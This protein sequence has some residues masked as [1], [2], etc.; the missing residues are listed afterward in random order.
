MIVGDEAQ[1]RAII[2][3]LRKKKPSFSQIINKKRLDELELDETL[4]E[5]F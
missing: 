2:K 4:Q 5:D 1:D 3:K